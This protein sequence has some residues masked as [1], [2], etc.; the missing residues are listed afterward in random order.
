MTDT[1]TDA[2][3]DTADADDA[4]ATGDT[5]DTTLEG[6]VV[7]VDVDGDADLTGATACAGCGRQVTL[8]G[9][10]YCGFCQDK[11][12]EHDADDE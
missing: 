5:Y 9:N 6:R 10:G 12:D 11:A 3:D 8:M 1:N 4:Q 7:P 2:T